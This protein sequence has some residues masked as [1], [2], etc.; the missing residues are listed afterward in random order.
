MHSD[1]HREMLL[2]R[3]VSGSLPG[4]TRTRGAAFAEAAAVCLEE[5]RHASG[6]DMQVLGDLTGRY[7][8]HWAALDENARRA[9]EDES[10]AAEH[11]AYGIAILLIT[12]QTGFS[13]V[14]RSVKGTGF[15]Y[16]LGND[17]DPDFQNKGR[18]EVSGK[19]RSAI[20]LH[21]R[22]AAK[23]RQMDRSNRDIPGYAVVVDFVTPATEVMER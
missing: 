22:A 2:T 20:G 21:Q 1:E 8:V 10:E 19:R 4:L 16:W 3:L 13:V 23:A 14:R 17:R 11:G 7:K 12:D 9:W 6:V 18:L 15:D 5:C